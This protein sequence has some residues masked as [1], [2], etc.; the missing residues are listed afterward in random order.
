MARFTRAIVR[1]PG[2]NFA[3]GLTMAALGTP[4]LELALEQHAAYCAALERCGLELTVLP[5]EPQHPDAPFVEDTA[6][7]AAGQALMSRPGAA[8][9]Q[10]EVPSIRAA[11]LPWF[12]ELPAINAPGMLDGGDVC[13]AERHVFIGIS[14]RTNPEGAR[15]LS[16]WLTG[17][18]YGST[19]ID[20]RGRRDLLHLKS[21]MT[22]LGDNRMVLI[23]ALVGLEAFR[24]YEVVRVPPEEIYAANCLRVNDAV[25]LPAGYP[26]MQAAL[27]YL[28]YQLITLEMSE[29]QKLDGGLSCLSLRF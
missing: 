28:G 16:D 13:E 4:D 19:C 3:D 6:V 11:L 21:G 23:E 25:L 9:R 12:P 18:G 29:F 1:R 5:S 15:Q 2:A 24:N 7:L 20:I 26:A 8:S 14:E 17:L 27:R 22:Y 10:G